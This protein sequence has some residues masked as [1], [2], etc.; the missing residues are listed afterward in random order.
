MNVV[1]RGSSPAAMTCGILLLAKARSFGQRIQVEILG[2]PTDIGVVSGPA[3]LHSAPLAGC[4]V[5]RELGSGALVVV[6]GPPSVPLATSLSADGRGDWFYLD[7]A[8]T[9]EHPATRCFMALRAER[10]PALRQ[11]GKRLVGALRSLGCAVEPA[12]LDLFFGA[13]VPPLTRL[14]VG[15][16][17]GRALSGER[18]LPI[19]AVLTGDA[20]EGTSTVDLDHALERLIPSVREAADA[21]RIALSDPTWGPLAESLEELV[22]HLAL[23]PLG[24]ILPPLDPATDAVAFG[25]GRAL[26]ASRGS[27]EAQLGL[28]ETYQFLGGKFTKSAKHVVDLPADL[29]PEDRL[30]R[31]RWF[32]T[33]TSEAAARVERIWRDLVDPPM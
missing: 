10:D 25:L 6:P 32:C 26:S 8:G 33:H 24:G 21:T 9:G 27:S 16:R 22:R 23:L 3:L 4:G 20:D 30:G 19:T 7:R 31:W 28:L 13:P 2:D 12:V 5:G 11:A 1:L 17:A 14:A 15:L 18:G 29:P